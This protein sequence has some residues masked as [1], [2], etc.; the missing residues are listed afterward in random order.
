VRAADIE[1]KLPG[2]S[3]FRTTTRPIHKL[4]LV[5]PVE[6][7][8]AAAGQAEGEDAEAGQPAPPTVTEPVQQKGARATEATPPA[9]EESSPARQEE[10][11]VTEVGGSPHGAVPNL[12]GKGEGYRGQQ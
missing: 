6:E 11:G 9:I 12:P 4:V 1:Y 3:V 10:D 2:E 7:Q 8:T 5:V